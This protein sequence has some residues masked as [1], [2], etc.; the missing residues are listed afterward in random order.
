MVM[1]LIPANARVHPSKCSCP[2]FLISTYTTY[3]CTEFMKKKTTYMVNWSCEPHGTMDCQIPEPA[4][5]LMGWAS[6]PRSCRFLRFLSTTTHN[7]TPKTYHR[8][9]V[10][11]LR[12]WFQPCV[13]APPHPLFS[14]TAQVADQTLALTLRELFFLFTGF[15]V[16][17]HCPLTN[18]FWFAHFTISDLQ[19]D[20]SAKMALCIVHWIRSQNI[21]K[22]NTGRYWSGW[23]QPSDCK[24]CLDVS[25]EVMTQ[26]IKAL[27]YRKLLYCRNIHVL[28]WVVNYLNAVC[29][30][31]KAMCIDLCML[32]CAA[33]SCFSLSLA[34]P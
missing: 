8:F 10:L 22:R 33:F 29:Y 30:S 9:V 17:P 32:N 2:K 21:T 27:R 16:R 31:H 11:L 6:Y 20:C 23:A 13:T 5:C 7:T 14:V 19:L 1:E 15:S 26:D 28:L 4:G 12:R 25:T 3:S 24:T 18:Y 34:P